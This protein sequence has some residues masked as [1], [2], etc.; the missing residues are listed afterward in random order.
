MSPAIS[1]TP[2]TF[3]LPAHDFHERRGFRHP[4]P[5]QRIPCGGALDEPA[6]EHAR[7]SAGGGVEHAG[8]ARRHALFAG[9]Q[10]DFVAAVDRA[11]PRRLRR[12]RRAHPH[13]HLDAVADDAVQRTVADPVDVAQLDAVHPQR[14]ARSHHDTAA[15][16]IELDDVERRAGSNAQPLALADGEM[17]DAPMPADDFAAEID[18]IAGLDRAGPEPAD[19]VGIAPGRYEADILAVLLVGD[20]KLKTPRQVAHLGLAHVAE[21]KAQIIELLARGREQEVALV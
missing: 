15:Q 12:T 6:A 1:F 8:L 18:D 17:N 5:R 10:F 4:C 20:F 7:L 9:D 19:D 13:E 21:R 14:L 3:S 11:Q 2:R 16:G